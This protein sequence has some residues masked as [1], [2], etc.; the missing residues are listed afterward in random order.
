MAY[1]NR[2]SLLRFALSVGFLASTT[3]SVVLLLQDGFLS[4]S[5]ILATLF[6]GYMAI[7]IGAN[8]AAN[9]L[10]VVV[11]SKAI[12]LAWALVIA[13][14]LEAAGAMISGE[15]VMHTIKSE[16]IDPAMI[17][18]QQEFVWIMLSA[19]LAS[20]IWIHLATWMNAPISTTHTIIGGMVGAG[21]TVG[22][23]NVTNWPML[24]TITSSWLI[25]PLFGGMIA[26]AL[27][28]MVKQTLTYQ[29]NMTR[30]AKRVVPILVA[31][32]G[33]AFS[34]Y[35]MLKGIRPIW[36]IDFYTA[37]LSSL[38]IAIGLYFIV[39]PAVDQA[40][41]RLPQSKL[42]I[43]TLFNLPLIF[44]AA[45][46]SFA[47]GAND[48]ANALGPV[49]AIHEITRSVQESGSTTLPLWIL[50]LGA[51][52]LALGLVLYGPRLIRVI[53][54]ELTELDQIRA[55]AIAM[56]VAITTIIASELSLPIS[57][58]HVTIGAI[59]GVG[60]LR[61]YLK[62]QNATTREKITHHLSGKNLSLINRFL[63]EFYAS[64]WLQKRRMLK[65][66]EA[67]SVMGELTKRERKELSTL[68]R[69]ELVK[70]SAIV[71]II[72]AWALTLPITGLLASLI[73]RVLQ[74]IL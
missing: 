9:S 19:L 52:G 53:G 13:A 32:M 39:H 56:A 35:L 22:G 12:N 49:A 3:L 67:H 28:Y 20:A 64:S 36:H 34:T 44:A 71:R 55:Y 24:A 63:D 30:A 38:V 45:L 15:N 16:V 11:G 48:V 31:A 72:T 70:R 37:L 29:T 68:Y 5:L 50:L 27:L 25:S 58:T 69:K 4:I 73:Y 21:I 33:W 54:Y 6:G 8:D 42:A 65:Q 51:A 1:I 26:A 18:N 46:F 23:L 47:H 62:R 74:K 40:A 43:N 59:L 14:I 66:L 2:L 57:T 61:E 17:T 10:G 60:F 41:D 7:T